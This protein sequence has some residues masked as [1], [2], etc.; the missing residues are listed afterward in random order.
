M[1]TL[2]HFLMEHHDHDIS[3]GLDIQK[4]YNQLNRDVFGRRLPIIQVSF[5]NLPDEDCGEYDPELKQIF[6]ASSPKWDSI[7]DIKRVLAHELIHLEIDIFKN[8]ADIEH[9]IVFD[10]LRDK[11]SKISG[12]DIVQDAKWIYLGK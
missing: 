4:L 10:E 8:D 7:E 6:I 5:K 1:K 3:V 11:Y 2:L 12:I 9:S